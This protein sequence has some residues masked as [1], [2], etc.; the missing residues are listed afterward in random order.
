MRSLKSTGGMTRGRGMSEAQR[1]LWVLS[2]PHCAEVNNAL[3]QFTSVQYTTSDQH[4][5][6]TSA[7]MAKDAQDTSD[8]MQFLDSRNPFNI[9]SQSLRSITSGITAPDSVN[10]DTAEAVGKKITESMKGKLVT[11]YVFRK[12][13]Q[14]VTMDTKS[15]IKVT[16]EVVQVD[17]NLLFQRLVTAGTR[18]NTLGDIMC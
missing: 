14:A 12:K 16:D 17:P 8:L 2:A 1:A 10:A 4:K 3:Q 11:E 9:S 18:C 15:T 7:R 6:A 5:E 13:E